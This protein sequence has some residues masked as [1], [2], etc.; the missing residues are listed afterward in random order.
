M[1]EILIDL[2]VWMLL[3]RLVGIL[4]VGVCSG[5]WNCLMNSILFFGVMVMMIVVRLLVW[6]CLLYF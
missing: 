2:L 1:V 6:V 4:M 5:I 3:I